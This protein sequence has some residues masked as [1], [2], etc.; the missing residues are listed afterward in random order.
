MAKSNDVKLSLLVPKVIENIWREE[1]PKGVDVRLWQHSLRWFRAE[2]ETEGLLGR[3]E[4]GLRRFRARLQSST[5]SWPLRRIGA[6]VVHFPYQLAFDTALPTIY[7]PWDLQHI[8]LPELFTPEERVWRTAHYGR[9]CRRAHFVVT[10]TE[11]TRKDVAST[12]GIQT[13]RIAVV[14]RDTSLKRAPAPE[15]ERARLLKRIGVPEAF[16]FFPAI[17]YPHKNHERLLEALA[18][19]RDSLGVTVPLVMSGRRYPARDAILEEALDRHGLREQARFVGSVD[20]ETLVALYVQARLMVFPSRFEGLGLPL[21]EAMQYGLPIA[22]SKASCIPEVAA[23]A[24]AY[25]DPLDVRAM[26][27]TIAGLWENEAARAKLAAHGRVRCADFSWEHATDAY[28]ALYRAAAGRE[29]TATE[30]THVA[31]LTRA[32]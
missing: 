20:E 28:R 24:A 2:N 13:N 23:D 32:D 12:F 16:A 31:S 17:T 8:H 3:L 18:V 6:E 11:A 21:L 4:T 27:C 19:M 25:F 10:A 5:V 26:A 14:Y 1:A 22:A 9:A 30:A 15:A 29:L 7:E